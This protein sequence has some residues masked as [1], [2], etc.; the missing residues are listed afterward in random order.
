ML[1][2]V[3]SE[4]TA[5][6]ENL[7]TQ[8]A[9]ELEKTVLPRLKENFIIYHKNLQTIIN[10]LVK[11]SL[12]HEDPYKYDQKISDL[13]I[14]ETGPILESEKTVQLS[15]RFSNFESQLDYLNQYYQFNLEFLD[16]KRLKM[17]SALAGYIKWDKALTRSEDHI[18]FH[19]FELAGKL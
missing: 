18:S 14:P 5:E 16:F 1:R 6:M 2:E 4:F 11:K 8:K 3:F 7:L 17:L 10:V 13:E 12:I 15:I 19:F 9:E